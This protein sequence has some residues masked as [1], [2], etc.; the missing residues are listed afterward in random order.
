MKRAFLL[1]TLLLI[2]C[3]VPAVITTDSIPKGD[4]YKIE[5]LAIDKDVLTVDVSYGGGCKKHQFQWYTP[6]L[7]QSGTVPANINLYLVHDAK[8]DRCKAYLY[9]QVTLNLSFL[10]NGEPAFLLHIIDAQLTDH[11]VYYAVP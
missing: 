6:A 11:E 7:A 4:D 3:S 1:L 9:K 2:S 10:N 5:S 8:N